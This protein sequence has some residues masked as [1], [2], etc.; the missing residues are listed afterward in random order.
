MQSQVGGIPITLILITIGLVCAGGILLMLAKA[1]RKRSTVEHPVLAP[2]LVGHDSGLQQSSLKANIKRCP[3]CHSTYT[4]ATLRYCLVDGAS[5]EDA[6]ASTLSYDPATTIKI[7]NR[8]DS[9][10]FPT[11]QYRPEIKDD[12]GKV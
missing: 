2:D 1:R 8:G 4:D 9:K 10:L 6:P 7:N 12:E 5:L 11:V 3:T